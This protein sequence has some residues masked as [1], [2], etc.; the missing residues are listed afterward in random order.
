M[1]DLNDLYYYAQVVE[2]GGFAPAGR[3][4]GV[5]KSRLSRRVAALEERLGVRLIHRSTRRFSVTEIGQTYYDH[6]K[7]M[8]VEAEA[9]Q[10]AIDS[11]Q[12]EPRG[13]IRLTCPV[14]L[15]H[16]HIGA[17]LADFMVR[18]PGITVH[19]EAT[20]RRVDVVN[21]GV[22]VAIRVRQP[23]LEDSDLVLKV[24]S[25]R[26]LALVASP[27][28]VQRFGMPRQPADLHGW[29]S[30]GLG[31]PGPDFRWELHGEDGVPVS[32]YHQP[33][34][35]TTDMI[36]LRRAAVAGVGVV[37]LPVLSVQRQLERGELVQLLP[38]WG[39]RRDIIHAVFPSRRG[40]LPA[41][42]TL[43]DSLAEFY[44][45]FDEA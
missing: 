33:R 13:V 1:E 27:F 44:Q 25:E 41:V 15:L 43:L 22:D 8:L 18:Y 29:P 20:N 23:P 5:P 19:L 42:R 40:L 34:F 7:A 2:Y 14:T 11:V 38:D 6:C 32:L 9:A 45:S 30:L 31:S 39:L 35:V 36:A 37:Q 12:A 4:L 3:S 10:E 21:E 28:L 16:V 17:F 24:L 26:G